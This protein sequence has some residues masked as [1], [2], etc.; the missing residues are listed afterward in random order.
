VVLFLNHDAGM[1]AVLKCADI[2][3]YQAKEAGRNLVRFGELK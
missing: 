1:E 2:A 3:M